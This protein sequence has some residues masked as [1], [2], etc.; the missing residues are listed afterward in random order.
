MYI[1]ICGLNITT[2]EQLFTNLVA[3][4]LGPKKEIKEKKVI[5]YLDLCK[6]TTEG[7]WEIMFGEYNYWWNDSKT[8]QLKRSYEKDDH[9]IPKTNKGTAVN[10]QD[11]ERKAENKE[12]ANRNIDNTKKITSKRVIYT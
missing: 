7:V 10:R 4:K 6:E 3:Q 5:E 8:I 12:N 2:F 9:W 1:F 11:E